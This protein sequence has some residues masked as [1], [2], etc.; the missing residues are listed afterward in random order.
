MASLAS[1]VQYLMLG[2]EYCYTV[3]L[4]IPYIA[5]ASNI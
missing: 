2:S 3:P 1:W 5:I 4:S